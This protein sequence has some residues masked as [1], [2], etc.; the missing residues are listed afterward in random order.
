M[1]I[2]NIFVL[3]FSSDSYNL[4]ELNSMTSAERYEL[5]CGCKMLGDGVT[6]VSTLKEFEEFFNS[7]CVDH[8]H[9]YIFF[10]VIG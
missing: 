2:D 8:E 5:A 4:E 1:A 3:V 6:E 10:H 7:G 9:S